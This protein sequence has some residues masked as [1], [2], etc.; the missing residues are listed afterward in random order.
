MKKALVL[1]LCGLLAAGSLTGC[2]D[3]GESAD[4]GAAKTLTVAVFD[5]GNAPDGQKANDNT[6]TKWIQE[7][8]GKPNN[9]NVEFYPIPR[10]QEVE[11]LNVLMASK[12]SP[13]ITLTYDKSV[14]FNY[15]KSGGLAK[16]DEYIEKTDKLKNL[17]GDNFKYTSYKGEI[18]GVP[19]KTVGDGFFCAYIRKDWLDKLNLPVPET[20]QQLRDTLMQFKEKDPGGLGEDLIPYLLSATSF[21]DEGWQQNTLHLVMSFVEPMDE[22]VWY[23][24]PQIKY[25][26]YKEG[27][28]YLNQMYHDGLLDQDF[29]LQTNWT[30][31]DE[32][33]AAG[34]FGFY[35]HNA[36]YQ[37]TSTGS[38]A[39][40]LK[41][42]P[43]AEIVAFDPFQNAQGRHPKWRGSKG[44]AFLMIPSFSKV[45]EEAVKYLDW[46]ADEDIGFTLMNGIEGENYTLQNGIPVAIDKEY[47]NENMFNNLDLSILY[48][49]QDYG[50]FEKNIESFRVS[51]SVLGDL[52]AE[53]KRIAALPDEDLYT[54]PMDDFDTPVESYIKNKPKLDKKYQELMIKSITAAPAEFDAVYDGLVAEYMSIGGDEVTKERETVYQD[55]KKRGILKP[56]DMFVK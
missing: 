28:R 37:I 48:N 36:N 33:I 46:M 39:M 5:R 10:K 20:T 27:V 23:T 50:S 29:A 52:R 16:L 15:A 51:D 40:L 6:W 55:A 11:Q 9:I 32:D 21:S 34:R 26:G 44:G 54:N 7:Q 19:P 49:G 2:G 4:G 1:M 35:M 43:E 41:N 14:F 17:I 18:F 38:Y 30:K 31:F 47:N 8:F 13:D 45:Q 3:K 53:S 12:S 22:E 56:N 42:N 24:Q 25:P